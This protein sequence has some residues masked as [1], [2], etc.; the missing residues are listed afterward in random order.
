LAPGAKVGYS[1]FCKTF[2][3][4]QAERGG[5]DT[6][7][8]NLTPKQRK[9]IETLLTSGSVSEAADLANVSRETLYRW[10]KQPDFRAELERATTQAIDD[11]SRSLVALGD[12]AA[13]TL[14]D[15]MKNQIHPIATR[16][17][18]ADVVF[19]RLLQLR[20]L[21]SLEQ[22]VTELEERSVKND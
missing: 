20:E 21:T 14:A 11:L 12:L 18:A 19:S 7:S 15:A 22:R 13:A 4:N 17:R 2:A 1:S 10:I 5:D 6:L 3:E 16:V 8:E 9:A